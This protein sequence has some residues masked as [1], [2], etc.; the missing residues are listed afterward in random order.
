MASNLNEMW[1][2]QQ[3]TYE[4]GTK[5]PMVMMKKNQ[6]GDD[7]T[8]TSVRI[9]TLFAEAT[10]TSMSQPYSIPPFHRSN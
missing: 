9:S 1:T 6:V 4:N 2:R 7:N 8:L 3:P 5:T 10:S